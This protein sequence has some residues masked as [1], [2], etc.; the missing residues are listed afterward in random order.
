ME[1]VVITGMGVMSPLGN[2]VE[3]FWRNL[4]EGKS[5]ISS[6]IHLMLVT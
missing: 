5:G 1:R 3:K 4:V 2:N 6:L